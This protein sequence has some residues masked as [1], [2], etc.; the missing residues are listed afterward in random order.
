MAKLLIT[1]TSNA[2]GGPRHVADLSGELFKLGERIDI[3]SPLDEPFGP[4]FQKQSEHFLELPRRRFSPRAW[5]RLLKLIRRQKYELIHSHGRG[6]GIYSRTLKPFINTKVVHTFHGVNES[7]HWQEMVKRAIDSLL[8][9][10]TDLFISVSEPEQLAIQRTNVAGRCPVLVIKNGI[11]TERF[12]FQQGPDS[13]VSFHVGLFFRDDP[14][15]GSDLFHQEVV[16]HQEAYRQQR[17]KFHIA[18]INASKSTNHPKQIRDLIEFEGVVDSA[19][20]LR[21]MHVIASFS[22][23]EGMPLTVI[24]ALS[25]GVPCLLSNIPAHRY[26]TPACALF[27]PANA[28]DFNRQLLN[29]ARDATKRAS[30][31]RSGRELVERE[32]TAAQ[33]AGRTARAYRSV[34]IGN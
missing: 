4:I 27:D 29:L 28:A 11:D 5:W 8:A 31:A 33:M 15:K 13:T 1:L 7:K 21:R 12:S 24:E 26:F 3:A 14:V 30:M 25:S 16:R 2:S 17:L 23:S 18:G 10:G 22:R 19:K 20:F 32:H 34:L 9:R 6:A